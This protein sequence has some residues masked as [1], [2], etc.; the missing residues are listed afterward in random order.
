MKIFLTISALI[1]IALSAN[2]QAV[3]PEF[4]AKPAYVDSNKKTLVELEKSQYNILTKAKGLFK[5]EGGFFSMEY[6]H[7]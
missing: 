1:L 3:L 4:N 6:P 7:L 5:G 2:V